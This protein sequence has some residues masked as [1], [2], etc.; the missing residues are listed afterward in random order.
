MQSIANV[1]VPISEGREAVQRVLPARGGSGHTAQM[2]ES[3]IAG[4]ASDSGAFTF[5]QRFDFVINL[6]LHRRSA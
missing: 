6:K 3:P 5:N 4:H 2:Q 1:S